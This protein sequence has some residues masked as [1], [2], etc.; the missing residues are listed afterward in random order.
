[1]TL[2]NHRPLLEHLPALGRAPISTCCDR[3]LHYYAV[4]AIAGVS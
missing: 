4:V 2:T 1:M 3:L